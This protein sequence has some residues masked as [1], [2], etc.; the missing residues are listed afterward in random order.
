MIVIDLFVFKVK[1]K[2]SFW[3]VVP[4]VCSDCIL[5]VFYLM[6]LWLINDYD[7]GYCLRFNKIGKI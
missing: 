4:A 5:D 6:L 3:L 1:Y 7:Y 2:C